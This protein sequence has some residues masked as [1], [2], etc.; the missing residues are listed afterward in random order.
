M[1]IDLIES[2]I[3]QASRC[4]RNV[5]FIWHGGE[6]LLAGVKVFEKI[7]QTQ[8]Q[9]S[10]ERGIKFRNKIQTNATLIDT[11]WIKIFKEG[12]FK[13][14]VSLDGSQ[15]LHDENRKKK[16]EKGSFSNTIAGIKTLQE[17]QI[18]F[19]ILAVVS[20]KSL[21]L[22]EEIFNFFVT[23]RFN[24]FDFLPLVEIDNKNQL[25]K[26]SL[27]V[28]DFSKFM[29]ELFDL[30]ISRD[31]DKISIRYLEQI[32]STMLG[33]KPSLCKLSGNCEDYITIDYNGKVFPCDNFIGYDEL[34][35]GDL[36]T[37]SLLQIIKMKNTIEIKKALSQSHSECQECFAFRFCNSGCN[38][39]R[40]MWEKDFTSPFYIC[41]DTK[42][43]VN[44]IKKYLTSEH[45][46]LLNSI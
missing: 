3:D 44:H 22:A 36:Q 15:W 41:E 13:V 11:N 20:K 6:P 34:K 32:L 2:V 9:I 18:D 39:Y 8:R 38:K 5:E 21:G 30:W 37:N 4:A 23:Q 31:D 17:S 7:I 43:I 1:S 45:P 35:Y 10:F 16:N 12:D 26:E 46:L 29:N 40:Y 42:I 24:Q 19:A 33:N 28:G 27:D 14:G 25:L